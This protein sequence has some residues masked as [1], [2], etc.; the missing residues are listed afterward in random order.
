MPD[1]FYLNNRPMLF[2]DNN[3]VFGADNT[4][5]RNDCAF[6]VPD[7]QTNVRKVMEFKKELG[8]EI[9]GNKDHDILLNCGTGKLTCDT[10]RYQMNLRVSM[11]RR[12]TSYAMQREF[13]IPFDSGQQQGDGYV[14]ITSAMASYTCTLALRKFCVYF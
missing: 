6:K 8:Q 1:E 4:Y 13:S 7:M 11:I 10:I 2:L 5:L 9:P 12:N 14:P 3:P